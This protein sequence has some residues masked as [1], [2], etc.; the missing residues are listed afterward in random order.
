MDDFPWLKTMDLLLL[1]LWKTFNSSIKN[2][3]TLK[4]IQL[5]YGMKT[6]V[7]RWLSHGAACKRSCER[8]SVI[9]DVLHDIISKNPKPEVIG[10]WSQLLNSKPLLQILF[11]EDVLSI[12]N[13]LLL[14]LQGDKKDFRAI[15]RAMNSTIT[16][17]TE[18]VPLSKHYPP[19]KF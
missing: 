11:L 2:R 15:R 13:R 12:T 8:Y 5:A 14:V 19:E 3:Y 1:G 4:K 7:T 16:F 18:M 9:V 17:I 6:S 10:Y